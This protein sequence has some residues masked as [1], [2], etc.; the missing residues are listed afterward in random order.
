MRNP[1]IKKAV[2][3]YTSVANDGYTAFENQF[4]AEQS[5]IGEEEY[6]YKSFET[7]PFYTKWQ[8]QIKAAKIKV[9]NL[10]KP[11]Q[12]LQLAQQFQQPLLW[13]KKGGTTLSKEDRMEIERAKTDSIVAMKETELVYKAI[14]HNNEMLQ[15][16]LIKVFK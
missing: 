15:K 1:D 2:D 8:D 16:A 9:D 13:Q 3:E 7:S 10:Y 4:K 12:D 5:R 11:I 6:P 14:L